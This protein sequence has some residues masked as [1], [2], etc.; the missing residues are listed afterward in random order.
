MAHRSFT[1]LALTLIALLSLPLSAAAS[2]K[3]LWRAAPEGSLRLVGQVFARGVDQRQPQSV[4]SSHIT[5]DGQRVYAHVKLLNKGTTRK[6]TMIWIHEGRAFARYSL[7]VGRSPAWK[8][9]SYLTASTARVGS[10]T[11][12]VQ[13]HEG[14]VLGQQTLVIQPTG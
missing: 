1:S 7:S 14:K 6:I 4:V 12:V 10:W 11:V 5:A 8:T 9:W 2:P 3:S 13:D